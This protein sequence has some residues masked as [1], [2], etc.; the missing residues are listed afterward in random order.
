[1][2]KSEPNHKICKIIKIHHI[3]YQFTASS[4]EL[5]IYTVNRRY[6][7]KKIL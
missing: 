5:L 7:G 6:I 3:T 2:R 1:M 4:R